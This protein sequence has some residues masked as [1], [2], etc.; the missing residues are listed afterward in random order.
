M[1][2]KRS[3]DVITA[4]SFCNSVKIVFDKYKIPLLTSSMEFNYVSDWRMPTSVIQNDFIDK[5]ILDNQLRFLWHAVAAMQTEVASFLIFFSQLETTAAEDDNAILSRIL[6]SHHH[7]L[8]YECIYRSWERITQILHYLH[9][10][11]EN[12]R[13]YFGDI[14]NA[15]GCSG[16]YSQRS[17]ADLKSHIYKWDKIAEMRNIFSHE[18]SRLFLYDYQPSKV[19]NYYGLP[20]SFTEKSTDFKQEKESLINRYKQI[21]S[22]NHSLRKFLNEFPESRIKRI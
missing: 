19:L 2:N 18:E 1:N 21:P 20:Y 5:H 3:L 14:V 17:I 22:V 10:K 9:Y 7:S 16:I 6:C 8:S 12:K 13:I 4:K 11:K 15:L